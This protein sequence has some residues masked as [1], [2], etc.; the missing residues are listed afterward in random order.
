MQKATDSL[1]NFET[2]KY[3]NAENHER[4]RFY[5]SLLAYKESNIVVAMS[6][7]TLNCVQALCI[8]AGL[9]LTLILAYHD[10]L[11]GELKVQDFVTFNVYIL[12]IYFPLQFIGTFW[13][14]IRQ[15]WTDVELVL[16]ILKVNEAI[17][18]DPD[19]IEAN[20]TAG[21]IEFKNIK[22]TYDDKLKKEDQR[23]ILDNVSFTVP[24]GKS[25]ALVGMTGSGKSTILRL[26]YRFYEIQEGQILIDGLDIKKMRV[27]DLRKNI[28]I[29]PQDCVLFNDTVA[30]NIAYGAVKEPEFKKLVDD[31][32]RQDE[33]VEAI[34]PASKRAQIYDFI[35][36][37][38]KR[39]QTIVGE[40]GLKLS[41]GEKQRMAI[42]RALL[43]KTRIMCFDEATSA[44]DTETERMVQ[45]AIDDISKDS[46]SLIIAHRLST[47]RNCDCI[48]ALKHGVIVEQ[49]SH[50]ELL[51]KAG[52]YYKELWEKQAKSMA[53]EEQEMAE[54]ARFLEEQQRV[55]EQRKGGRARPGDAI[56]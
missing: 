55:L 30:Y 6:L 37:K 20:I 36:K 22:F 26:L 50:D 10:I 53:A 21:K 42:A 12:Q 27:Q 44:L 7:V 3:F 47:V 13:R 16:E 43:K 54:K 45:A 15:N 2:V 25:Y 29:V 41:G 34:I 11:A 32:K 51:G 38:N 46:T 4:D 56:N 48:I 8:S 17:A 24:A 14:F 31:P 5:T 23:T 1:L 18:D 40:R 9:T 33:L 39:W 52:G 19:A 35:L 49:G 28:A